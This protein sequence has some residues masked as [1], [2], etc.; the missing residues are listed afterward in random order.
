ML[1]FRRFASLR[2]LFYLI[3][4]LRLLFDLIAS[5]LLLLK[6]IRGIIRILRDF[7]KTLLRIPFLLLVFGTRACLQMNLASYT[8]ISTTRVDVW[9][10][11][12]FPMFLDVAEICA[13]EI[14]LKNFKVVL[15][16]DV[17]IKKRLSL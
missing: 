1:Q 4:S 3:A 11:S 6:V 15:G 17:L 9:P 13:V 10:T 7:S 14:P 5:Q 12:S 2:L 16:T 8:S